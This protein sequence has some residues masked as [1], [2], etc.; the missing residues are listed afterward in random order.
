MN[1]IDLD[2]EEWN[3]K[4]TSLTDLMIA[5]SFA[6]LIEHV[7]IFPTDTLKTHMQCER[8]MQGTQPLRPYF[9]M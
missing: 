7:S 2:W 4:E 9:S 6:F 1:D 3:T 5:D 8:C